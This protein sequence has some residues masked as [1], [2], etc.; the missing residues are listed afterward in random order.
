MEKQPYSW[1][2]AE[3]E[4]F[5]VQPKLMPIRFGGVTEDHS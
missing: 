3:K 5:V 2:K 4:M 1:N